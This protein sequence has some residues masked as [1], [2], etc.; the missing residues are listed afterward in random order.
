MENLN[1]RDAASGVIFFV[2]GA[3]FAL[4]SRSLEMGSA[5]RM[6]PGY[7]P[8]VLSF[9]LM[10]VGLV[11]I[12]TSFTGRSEPLTATPW[13]G[14]ILVLAAPVVFALTVRKLGLL[15]AIALTALFCVYASRRATAS[16]AV[17]LCIALTLFCLGVFSYGL[18]LPLPLLGPW[19]RF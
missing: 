14:L 9:I 16:L 11:I 18:G 8:L 1:R 12:A 4:A 19:L 3:G 7:F 15:P 17:L 6:G 2:I 5:L 10:A 13:R